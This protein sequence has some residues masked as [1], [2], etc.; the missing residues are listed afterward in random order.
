MEVLDAQNWT[1]W[2]IRPGASFCAKRLF[3]DGPKH[4]MCTSTLRSQI[5]SLEQNSTRSFALFG[6]LASLAHLV[7]ESLEED[8]DQRE[9]EGGG[10]D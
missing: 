1:Q 2:R 6:S 8:L 9:M 5:A 3:R 10:N 7:D 4:A